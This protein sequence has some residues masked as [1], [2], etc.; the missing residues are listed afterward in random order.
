M[1]AVLQSVLAALPLLPTPDQIDDAV[2]ILKAIVARDDKLSE[3]SQKLGDKLAK[4][5]SA[6]TEKITST[7]RR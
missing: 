2:G 5:I 4:W 6:E 3:G 1:P 7:S